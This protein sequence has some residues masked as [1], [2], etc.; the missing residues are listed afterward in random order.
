MKNNNTFPLPTC[1]LINAQ[2]LKS[3]GKMEELT[4]NLR[5]LYEYR[6]ACLIACTETWL[7]PRVPSS[8][9]EPDGFTAYRLDRDPTIT[10]KSRA[11]GSLLSHS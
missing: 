10:K 4:A 3:P 6:T 7:H 11:G 2:S 5:H 1:L 9:V 8:E